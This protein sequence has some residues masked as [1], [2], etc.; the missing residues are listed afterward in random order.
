MQYWC[1]SLSISWAALI[2]LRWKKRGIVTKDDGTSK[3]YPQPIFLPQSIVPHNSNC[4]NSSSLS[5]YC[6]KEILFADL[7][8]VKGFFLNLHLHCILKMFEI[9]SIFT[10]KATSV[11]TTT[12]HNTAIRPLSLPFSTLLNRF[13]KET[14]S[15]FRLARKVW[16]RQAS[17]ER[18]GRGRERDR[19]GIWKRRDIEKLV[20]KRMRRGTESSRCKVK[21]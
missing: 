5:F 10:V 14:S 16:T 7:D 2:D 18:W 19:D 3:S 17:V 1:W 12:A 11:L 15:L 13:L 9:V 6:I 4:I 8:T 20:N 21:I